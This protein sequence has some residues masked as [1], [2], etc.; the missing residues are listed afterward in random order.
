MRRW[1]WIMFPILCVGCRVGP[2]Y[3]PPEVEVPSEFTEDVP[4]R[5]F[6]VG[7]DDLAGWWS[8]FND[9]FLDHLLD[10]GLEQNFDYLIAMER[11]LQ[12][13]AQFRVTFAMRLPDFEA[14]G[15]A[16]RFRTSRSFASANAGSAAASSSSSSTAAA[17]AAAGTVVPQIQD[18]FQLGLDAIWELDLFGKF[19]RSADAANDLWEASLADMRGVKISMISEIANTY[20]LICAYQ[21][22]EEIEIETIAIDEELLALARTR[23]DSG[24]NNEQEVN[25][26]IA[27]L[28][29]ERANLEFV[30]EGLKNAIYSLA[31]LLGELPEMVICEF[32][33]KR[34]IPDAHGQVPISVP[35]EL[36]R[37]RPDVR[38]AERQLASATEQIGVA[39]ADLFP[40]VS[41]SGSSSSFAAN[42]LQGA[43]VGVS[44]DDIAKLFRPASI[45]WGIGVFATAP[46]FDFGKRKAAVDL[47]ISVRNQTYY[48]YQKVVISAFQETEQALQ[49]YF[50]E[51]MRGQSLKIQAEIN[52]KTFQLVTDLFQAGLADYSQVINA[53]SNW[54]N[55]LDLL[56]G[57]QQALT[58]DLIA[59]YKAIGGD[60]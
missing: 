39:V 30:Q 42:P 2:N 46:V 40:S 24:L 59:V 10:L 19:R 51:E 11:V 6:D 45:V 41:L 8:R 22:R 56:I 48:S 36:L 32:Q 25:A 14:A 28:E 38:S 23:L 55:S 9:P 3:R 15:T 47:Q 1:L 7:D 37:R 58:Q 18:F 53:Q 5:T 50:H 44:S 43:N 34:A 57:S 52:A 13:R 21:G 60:W 54:L 33:T 4:E 29:N 12:A 26:I 17:A 49:S 35:S 31:I 20:A 16:S 27:I